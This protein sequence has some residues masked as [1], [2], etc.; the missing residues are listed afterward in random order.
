MSATPKPIEWRR[1]R[2][3][4]ETGHVDGIELFSV[5]PSTTSGSNYA[6]LGCDLPG[7]MRSAPIPGGI[8][9]AKAE[10]ERLLATFVERIT[11]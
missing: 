7:T 2:F 8:E 6:T 3:G 5:G 9:N 4:F 11:V 10:A 1:A